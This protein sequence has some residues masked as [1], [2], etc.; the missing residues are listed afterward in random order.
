MGKSSVLAQFCKGQFYD[1]N[2]T[3]IGVEFAAKEVELDGKTVRLQIWDTAG[4]ERAQVLSAA[5]YRR[6]E[7]AILVF[8]MTRRAT[9]DHAKHWLDQLRHYADDIPL[10]LVGNKSDLRHQR[11]VAAEEARAFAEAEGMSYVESSAR[12][13]ANI[14]FVFEKL[15]ADMLAKLAVASDLL[16]AHDEHVIDLSRVAVVDQDA[17]PGS[18]HTPSCA[19]GV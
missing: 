1:N 10:I 12:Q 2:L 6:A 17:V 11:Q 18:V 4:Q 8:D 16:P 19:C 14:E 7:G 5:F 3:T 15:A 13:N 9:F